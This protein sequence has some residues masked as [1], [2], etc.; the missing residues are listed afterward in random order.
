MN[1]TVIEHHEGEGQFPT[2]AKG[3]IVQNMHACE[4]SRHWMSCV[5]Q[6]FETYVPDIFVADGVLTR[7]YNPTELVAAQGE[8][9]EVE[10]IVYEWLFGKNSK[11]LSGWIPAEKVISIS[12]T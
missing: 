12:I 8:V 7:E 4:E 1:V 9:I 3:T 10:A 2:F 6:G 5:L 11:G